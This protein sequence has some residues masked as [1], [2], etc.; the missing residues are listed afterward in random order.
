MV[1]MGRGPMFQVGAIDYGVP[2][3]LPWYLLLGAI[4]GFAAVGFSRLLYWVE[5][6]FEKLP[7][8]WMW[9]PAIGCVVLGV[10]GY[11]VPRVLGV[12]Y[13]TISDILNVHLVLKML[14][15]VMF[16]KALVRLAT[17]GSGTAGV[18]AV[19]KI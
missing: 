1:L 6:Q 13:D 18:R 10:V 15:L 16:C 17:I 14:L 5:D 3:V 12:G 8:D 4:C 11:F 9:W 2:R 19:A 7:I